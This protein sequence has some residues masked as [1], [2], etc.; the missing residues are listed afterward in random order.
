MPWL[1]GKVVHAMLRVMPK[2]P[3]DVAAISGKRV[4]I[5]DI[6]EKAGVHFTT[7]SL[8][9]RDKPRLPKKTRLKIQA[10]ARKL[11]YRP[12]PRLAV[13]NTYRQASRAPHYQATLAWINNW[14]DRQKMY[15][16]A[17]FQE[18]YDGARE[19]ADEL[20]YIL[21]E[22]WLRE[23]SMTPDRMA[24]IL[25]A[26]GISGIIMA[27]QPIAGTSIAFPYEQFSPVSV[28]FGLQPSILHV[29]TNH[30]TR[31]VNLVLEKIIKMGYRRIGLCIDLDSDAKADYPGIGQVLLSRW[32]HPEIE[33]VAPL[34]LD[35]P[36]ADLRKW[37]AQ[38]KPDV[39]LSWDD[40]LGRL[41][42]LD[43]RV[44]QDIG[45][46]S[47]C[48]GW[49]TDKVR[50]GGYQNNDIIGRTAVETV[51]SML[52]RSER[53]IPRVAQRILIE[54]TW[55]PGKTLKRQTPRKAARSAAR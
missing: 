42:A 45:F 28:G 55:Y 50:A 15:R 52:N 33:T 19:R 36:D 35:A 37:I 27:P 23:P 8:A 24:R 38:E 46:A 34:F 9:L 7:V 25:K 40:I 14:P 17:C 47:L 29:V 32:K 6:A 4:T 39:V 26:R 41:E 13:L 43:L 1:A 30:Q 3:K 21:E 18:Y 51:V 54:S 22:F 20:G 31:N 48:I 11:G 12:D 44:P 49:S 5:R 10:L 2:L 53:G 16:T